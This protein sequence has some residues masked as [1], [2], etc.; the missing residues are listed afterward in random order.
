MESEVIETAARAI[1]DATA[2][3]VTAGAGMGVDSGLPDFRGDEGFWHAYPP[4]AKLGLSFYDLANPEW[5]VRDPHLAWGFY[6]HRLNLYQTTGPHEGFSVLLRWRARKPDGGFVFTSNVDG[7]FQAAGF[8]TDRVVECHGSIHHTQCT[9]ECGS[10]I[11]DASHIEVAVDPSTC[12]A[13]DPLPRCARC[14]A[15]L[16]PNVLMF[17]DWGWDNSRTA[18]QHERM[19]EWLAEMQRQ[20]ARPVIIECGAGTAVPTVRITGEALARQLRCTLVRIN[21]DERDG[22]SNHQTLIRSGARDA[23]LELDRLVR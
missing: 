8:P 13:L 1:D 2:L 23:L 5:F 22:G 10:G 17:G 19:A 15:L 4:F 12:R 11:Q 21:P 9:R 3:I 18:A 14:G 6:G 16:R 20:G 7:Q